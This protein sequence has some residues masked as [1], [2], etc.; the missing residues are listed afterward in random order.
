MEELVRHCGRNKQKQIGP[1]LK[2]LNHFFT[3]D[4]VVHCRNEKEALHIRDILEKRFKE[5]QLELHEEKTKIIYC[6]DDE[7]KGLYSQKQFDFLGYTFRPRLVRNTKSNKLFV[8]FTPAVSKAALKAMRAKT[9]KQGF[10]N[11]TDWELK[12]ISAL[13]NPVLRGW[14]EY[15]GRYYSSALDAVWGHF[16]KT[17]LA[18]AMHKYK[19]LEG[20]RVRTGIWLQKI[21]DKEPNLFVHWRRNKVLRFT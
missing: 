6:K 8:C 5:C 12:E 9:R 2:L 19:R 17:L 1:F 4:G 13:Y 15:Y 7:R 14:A 21:A 10:R 16:N 11:R 20:R 18:W 3:L